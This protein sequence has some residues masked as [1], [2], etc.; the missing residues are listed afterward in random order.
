MKDDRLLNWLMRSIL[1]D[2]ADLDAAAEK[3]IVLLG[4]SCHHGPILGSDGANQAI[5]DAMDLAERLAQNGGQERLGE[6]YTSRYPA[7]KEYV[8]DNEVELAR[9]HGKSRSS[10]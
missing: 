5:N 2:K 7:W 6:F 9:M 4:D 10:L 8:K 3:G 1:V